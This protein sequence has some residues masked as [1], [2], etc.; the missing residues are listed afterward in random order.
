VQGA[1][2]FV[3]DEPT[4]HLDIPA[5]ETLESVL[6]A[7]EGT[8]LLVSHD[9]FLVD[10]LA[11]VIWHIEDGAMVTFTGSY[12]EYLARRDALKR[13]AK[14]RRASEE[15]R[16]A[17]QHNAARTQARR[18]EKEMA[19]I[20]AQIHSLEGAMKELSELL[21]RAKSP[22]D[23]A[24]LGQQYADHQAQL[25]GLVAQWSERGG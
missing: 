11:D 2:F 10:R 4:N 1:N 3:L 23:V 8:I 16:R 19:Q 13:E 20:E 6:D 21:E 15:S 7:F 17:S 18:S 12:Q 24:Q 22:A 5:Q 25:E 9:R 14:A